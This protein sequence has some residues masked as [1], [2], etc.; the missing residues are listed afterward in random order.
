[1]KKAKVK[2]KAKSKRA[3]RPKVDPVHQARRERI[4]AVVMAG[5][6][7]NGNR[8][9]EPLAFA[10]DALANADALIDA[11]DKPKAPETVAL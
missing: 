2:A 8:S 4:A 5:M 7:S 9:G 10:S 3:A 1:M 11:I 6:L